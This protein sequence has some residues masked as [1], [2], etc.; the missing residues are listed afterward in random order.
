MHETCLIIIHDPSIRPGLVIKEDTL[1]EYLA[2]CVGG[3]YVGDTQKPTP[4]PVK[5][6]SVSL[7]PPGITQHCLVK[8][9]QSCLVKWEEVAMQ[10][11]IWTDFLG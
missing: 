5:Y 8:D 11:F 9:R 7:L 6:M 10:H 3:W 4:T 2:V 1:C